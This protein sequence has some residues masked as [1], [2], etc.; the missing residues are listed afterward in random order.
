MY[1]WM[2]TTSTNEDLLFSPETFLPSSSLSCHSQRGRQQL[3]SCCLTLKNVKCVGV[4][5][6][7]Q[8]AHCAQINFSQGRRTCLGIHGHVDVPSNAW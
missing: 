4:K 3:V 6:Y 1:G 7:H 5:M 2:A 8:P